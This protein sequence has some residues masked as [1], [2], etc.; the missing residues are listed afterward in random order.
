MTD[1]KI[2]PII[3]TAPPPPCLLLNINPQAYNVLE[4]HVT[5]DYKPSTVEFILYFMLLECIH[6]MAAE[7]VFASYHYAKVRVLPWCATNA[8]CRLADL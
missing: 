4:V 7:L 8:D 5:S 2:F 1:A 6:L 3:I